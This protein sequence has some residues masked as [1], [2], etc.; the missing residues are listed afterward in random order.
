MSTINFPLHRVEG[1]SA[2]QRLTRNEIIYWDI[3]RI[4]GLNIPETMKEFLKNVSRREY[5]TLLSESFDAFSNPIQ[6]PDYITTI[7]NR[8]G[9]IRFPTWGSSR[10]C[11]DTSW[12]KWSRPTIDREVNSDDECATMIEGV[13]FTGCCKECIE[14]GKW[15]LLYDGIFNYDISPKLI[16]LR[17]CMACVKGNRFSWGEYHDPNW[18][19]DEI[20]YFLHIENNGP[21]VII[22]SENSY[23][24]EHMKEASYS[25]LLR[26]IMSEIHDLHSPQWSDVFERLPIKIAHLIREI[27]PESQNLDSI[28]P[29]PDIFL[30]RISDEEFIWTTSDDEITYQDEEQLHEDDLEQEDQDYEVIKRKEQ[31]NKALEIIDSIMETDH[32]KLDQGKYLE[33]CQLLRNI[34]QGLM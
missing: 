20:Q 16:C 1:E 25:E 8:E 3:S 10:S 19:I 4:D 7:A 9:S 33:L 13:D 2:L 27:F 28:P 11:P 29:I 5:Y 24:Y 18:P 31:A 34:H 15:G 6:M 23:D 14:T 21:C 30:G 32:Q 22:P 17:G 12:R 26:D